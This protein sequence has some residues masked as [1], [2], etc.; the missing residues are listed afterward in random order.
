M[1]RIKFRSALMIAGITVLI[2]VY[3][4]LWQFMIANPVELTK[5]D[6]ISQYTG[7]RIANS[8][9]WGK[10]YNLNVQI[11]QEE[12]ILGYPILPKDFPPFNHPPFILP[13]LALVAY[14]EYLPAYYAWAAIQI[15]LCLLNAWVL[16][17]AVPPFRDRKILFIYIVLFFPAFISILSGQDSTLLLL[18]ISLW[19]YGLLKGK[20][21]TAGLGLALATIRPQIALLLALPF[22]FKRRKVLWWFVGA[23]LVLGVLSFALVGMQGTLG[24]LEILRISAGGEGYY[25]NE[26]AMVNFLG[27]LIRWFPGISSNISHLGGWVMYGLIIVFLCILW[28]RS[29]R[30]EEK[31]IGLAVLLAILASPHLHY[32]DLVLF[33]IPIIC[34]I[35]SLKKASRLG[36]PLLSLF[37][38]GISWILL[39]SNFLDVLK[40]NVPYLVGLFLGLFLWFPGI[41]FRPRLSESN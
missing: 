2:V 28:I 40:Y 12:K 33:L 36:D 13:V 9:N 1:P 18:G 23:A 3:G 11:S 30:I 21:R 10:V 24:Y 35:S 8:G 37:P 5:K 17:G 39:I 4:M 19:A 29:D 14:L 6:F 32:H 31:Q 27:L 38:L 26:I 20:D 15:V 7:G 22:L 16:L 34:L 25:M 41:F